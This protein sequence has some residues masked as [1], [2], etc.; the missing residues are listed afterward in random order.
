M[1][2]TL[3]TLLAPALGLALASMATTG[4]KKETPPPPPLPPAES[5]TAPAALELK[6]IDAAVPEE[7]DDKPK[8]KGGGHKASG[9]LS[10]CCA[11]LAQNSTMAPE[12][13]K[14]YMVQ[15]AAL[16]QAA[17]AQGKDKAAAMGLILGAL[18]GAGVPTACK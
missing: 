7:E 16:C 18:K 10:A 6:P 3:R 5:A 13:T 4:C 1:I 17:A 8:G 12:P 14:T 15:A 11:A 9:G 2:V